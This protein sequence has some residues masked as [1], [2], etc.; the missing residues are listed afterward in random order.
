MIL[1]LYHRYQHLTNTWNLQIDHL[2]QGSDTQYDHEFY[3]YED[4]YKRNKKTESQARVHSPSSTVNTTKR[5]TN[6]YGKTYIM[7]HILRSLCRE[8][9]QQQQPTH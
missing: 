8:R 7:A 4:T 1:Q 2:L 9:P 3:A 6:I 5:Y